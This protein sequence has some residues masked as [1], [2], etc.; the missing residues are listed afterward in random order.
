METLLE[1]YTTQR[2]ETTIY[3]YETYLQ[4]GDTITETYIDIEIFIKVP[5]YQNIIYLLD[6]WEVLKFAWIQYFALFFLVYIFLYQMLLGFVIKQK[7]FESVEISSI[8]VGAII[9]IKK[10]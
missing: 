3:N 2:N 7:V 9:G 1:E 5:T 6:T 8:N 4:Y 10:H